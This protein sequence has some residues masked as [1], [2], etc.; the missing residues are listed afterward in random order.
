MST[1]ITFANQKG[2]VGKTTL[3]TLFANYLSTKGEKILVIDS[4]N[5]QSISE[6][7]K[8]DLIKYSSSA[9]NYNIQSFS[10]SDQQSVAKLMQN[11]KKMD[12]TIL[13]DS[14]GHL[15]QQG[16]IPIFAHSDIIITP[17][18]YEAT[19]INSTITFI[20]FITTMKEKISNMKT[21]L[22]LIPNRYD[23]R[24]GKLHEIELWEKTDNVFSKYGTVLPKIPIKVALQRY[25]TISLLDDQEKII[26]PTFSEIQKFI[27]HE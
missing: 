7:R 12:G 20:Q 24:Y 6:K 11:L 1:I 8:T 16:L 27:A 26:Q 17:Y 13:I 15:S 23:K 19:C 3:C 14:P 22:L 10:I 5:Q 4:D 9:I 21:R 2:G 25:N 18:Q